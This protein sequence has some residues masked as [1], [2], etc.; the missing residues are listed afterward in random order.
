MTAVAARILVVGAIA[1][2]AACSRPNLESTG[3]G[4]APDTSAAPV[5]APAAAAP[6]G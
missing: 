2:A 6:G 4:Y 1:L 3:G 5:A